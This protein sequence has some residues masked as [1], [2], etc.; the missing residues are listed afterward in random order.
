M[1]TG[2]V[3]KYENETGLHAVERYIRMGRCRVRRPTNLRMTHVSC[4]THTS[5]YQSFQNGINRPIVSC[6]PNPSEREIPKTIATTGDFSREQAFGATAAKVREATTRP[7]E[8][9]ESLDLHLP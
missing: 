3:G 7:C 4:S 6:C 1:L 2:I 8:L 5:G 9:P